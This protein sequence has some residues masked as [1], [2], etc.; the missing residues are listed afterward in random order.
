MT[1]SAD[2]LLEQIIDS[3][4]WKDGGW[5]LMTHSPAMEQREQEADRQFAV[6]H[7]TENGGS[8]Y[9]LAEENLELLLAAC[10][11]AGGWLMIW[12]LYAIVG[13]ASCWL[14]E[15]GDL[16]VALAVLI[17]FLSGSMLPLEFFP[18]PVREVL[19]RLPFCYAFQTPLSL[20]LGRIT[21][22]EGLWQLGA[23]LVWILLLLCVLKLVWE[24]ARKK[25]QGY[26]GFWM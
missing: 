19:F 20:Y 16:G 3:A 5:Y 23:M 6:F 26:R 1:L 8:E 24:S 17:A 9:V 25:L 18:Q 10:F 22:E 15:L 7:V 14:M 21:P 12:I 11:A 2:E 4:N 13:T